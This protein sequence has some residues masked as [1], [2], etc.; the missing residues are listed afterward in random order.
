MESSDELY[1]TLREIERALAAVEKNGVQQLVTHEGSIPCG[2]CFTYQR[3]VREALH[4]L[5]TLNLEA[6]TTAD[7]GSNS[8][9]ST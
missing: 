4:L 1:G 9:G 7:A 2:G 3:A 6:A 8:G 5:R